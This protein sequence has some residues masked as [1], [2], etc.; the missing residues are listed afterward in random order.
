MESS[1]PTQSSERREW[2]EQRRWINERLHEESQ[3]T[4]AAIR[5]ITNEIRESENRVIT[6]LLHGVM[7]PIAAVVIITELLK[8]FF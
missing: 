7:W 4:S 1:D 8:K 6:K 3:A 2:D 5:S